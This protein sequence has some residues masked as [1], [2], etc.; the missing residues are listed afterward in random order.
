VTSER[1]IWYDD[2]AGPLVRPYAVTRGR[3]R[4]PRVDLQLITLVVVT[5]TITRERLALLG[6]EHLQILSRCHHPTSMAE[7]SAHLSLPLS[8]V[9]ILIGDLVDLR[10]VATRSAAMPDPH[11]LQAVL[12]GIRRL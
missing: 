2:E 6:P 7:L 3:T 10:L 12:N 4:G 8:I 5:Q 11:V 1:E 9:K